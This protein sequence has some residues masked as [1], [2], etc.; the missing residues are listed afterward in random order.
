M[1]LFVLVKPFRLSLMRL[2]TIFVISFVSLLSSNVYASPADDKRLLIQAEKFQA[3]LDEAQKGKLQNALTIWEAL[4]QSGN[5]IPELKRALE[6]NIA[7]VFIKQ[8]RYEEAKK[9]LD[10][11]LQSDAQ[12]ATTLENLNQIYAY[13]AQKAYQR[14]FKET[15]VNSPKA[16]WLYFDVKQAKL[17]TNN[18]ITDEKNAD[19]VRVIKK[20]LEQW[21]QAWSNQKVKDY[22]SFYDKN[23]FIPKNGMSYKTWERGRYR[24]LQNP[25]FIKLFFDDIQVTPI[26]STMIRTR[27]LQRYHSDRFKDNVYKVLLWQKNNAQW[28]IVQ[29]VVIYGAN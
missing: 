22:L 25:K 16:E 5:L 12:V 14:I 7:V 21:R 11:A 2:L 18:V 9:R 4:N 29:E 23:N 28:K 13:D 3:G 26:S 10:S 24:S 20:S 17:P 27:F 6:N 8:K 19:A 15:P 1:S